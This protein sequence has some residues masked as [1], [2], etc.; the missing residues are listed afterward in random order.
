MS[1][2]APTESWAQCDRNG[3]RDDRRR[4]ACATDPTRWVSS[5]RLVLCDSVALSKNDPVVGATNG[6]ATA[7]RVLSEG[8]VLSE[9]DLLAYSATGD[10]IVFG[11]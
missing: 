5:E 3:P 8:L 6:D 11:E 9:T 7:L 2:V 4:H 1:G 10:G